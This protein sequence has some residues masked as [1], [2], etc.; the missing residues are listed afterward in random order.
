MVTENNNE[1]YLRFRSVEGGLGVTH[2]LCALED[3]ESERSQKVSGC[4][5]TSCWSESEAGAFLHE[6]RH[7]L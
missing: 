7:L 2:V 3:P 6:V 4:E 1:S 5:Q